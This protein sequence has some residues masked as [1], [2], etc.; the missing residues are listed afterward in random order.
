MPEPVLAE[1]PTLTAVANIRFAVVVRAKL[2]TDAPVPREVLLPVTEQALY[3]L[4]TTGIS[5][6]G[7]ALQ[8]LSADSG[9]GRH[10]QF[11]EFGSAQSRT[12]VLEP[13][14]AWLRDAS[15]G[16]FVPTTL[17]SWHFA[18]TNLAPA[19]FIVEEVE[20]VDG[21]LTTTV[22]GIV[23]GLT[24]F[25]AVAVTPPVL[26]TWNSHTITQAI[27]VIAGDSRCAAKSDLTIDADALR[28]V[29][30]SMF[31]YEAPGLTDGEKRERAC[32][33]QLALL[34]S[35]SDP[36]PLDGDPGAET[37]GAQ[38]RFAVKHGLRSWD[39]RGEQFRASL[40]MELHKRLSALKR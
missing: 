37:L 8:R 13:L 26:D 9:L 38:K 15:S 11:P 19:E 18:G 39:I 3:S 1:A 27:Q 24:M 22:K 2:E 32:M 30:S 34:L 6:A 31:N 40:V 4:L 12:I 28:Q 23:A 10:D 35:E 33:V 16:T 25:A 14:A 7:R 17:A 5:D 29:G 20:F 21:S 36:G